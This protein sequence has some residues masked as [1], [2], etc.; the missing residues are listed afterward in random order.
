MTSHLTLY[1]TK[2]VFT[3]A[4]LEL[5]HQHPH[6]YK[7]V[8]QTYNYTPAPIIVIS[9]PSTIHSNL[10][11]EYARKHPMFYIPMS[12]PH[13]PPTHSFAIQVLSMTQH[14]HIHHKNPKHV[15]SPQPYSCYIFNFSHSPYTTQYPNYKTPYPT[16][17]ITTTHELFKESP[18]H[19][20]TKSHTN[21]PLHTP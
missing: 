8:S 18:Q 2:R 7:S 4:S 3:G 5:N 19:P 10:S 12:P 20:S 14:T 13:Q 21:T 9:P 15:K 6:V 17:H 16:P 1:P 11:H